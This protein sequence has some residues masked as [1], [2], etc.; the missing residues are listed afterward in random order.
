MRFALC[1]M[2]FALF[3]PELAVESSIFHY[4]KINRSFIINNTGAFAGCSILGMSAMNT[5]NRVCSVL[6]LVFLFSGL[7]SSTAFACLNDQETT[8]VIKR[9]FKS[10]YNST[11]SPDVQTKQTEP[12]NRIISVAAYSIIGL[13]LFL[14]LIGGNALFTRFD[15]DDPSDSLE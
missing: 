4:F 6:V 3:H 7:G 9:E 12:Q 8:N 1:V 14:F 13:G 2:R 15:Q 5:K 11:D 10:K